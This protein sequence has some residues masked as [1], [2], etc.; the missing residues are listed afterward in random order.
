MFAVL[1]I[2][3]AINI[4]GVMIYS[5]MLLPSVAND[6]KKHFQELGFSM[7]SNPKFP[8]NMFWYEANRLNHNLQD[9]T[10]NRLLKKR[11]NFNIYGFFS[12]VFFAATRILNSV[13]NY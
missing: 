13:L 6:I 5:W 4:I 10:I 7:E 11:I 3:G 9:P 2:I 8:R 1:D 12:M